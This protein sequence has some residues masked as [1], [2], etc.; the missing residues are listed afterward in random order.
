MNPTKLASSYPIPPKVCL[1]MVP[2]NIPTNPVKSPI[3]SDTNDK[4]L[5]IKSSVIIAVQ[6]LFRKSVMTLRPASK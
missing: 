6:P 2:K 5:S 4:T 1:S 3:A